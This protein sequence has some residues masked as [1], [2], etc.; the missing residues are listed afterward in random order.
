MHSDLGREGGSF[1]SRQHAIAYLFA[2]WGKHE[3]F[4]DKGQAQAHISAKPS[5]EEVMLA[6]MLHFDADMD[7]C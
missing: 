3:S 7:S 2:W 6:H 1:E 4:L 5:P